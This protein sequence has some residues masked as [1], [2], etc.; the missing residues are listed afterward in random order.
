LLAPSALFEHQPTG[1]SFASIGGRLA[2]ALNGT[3]ARAGLRAASA[4]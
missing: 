4:K 1:M 2:E 3:L